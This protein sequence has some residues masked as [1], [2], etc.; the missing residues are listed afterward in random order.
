MAKTSSERSLEIIRTYVEKIGLDKKSSINLVDVNNLI[1][2]LV[3]SANYPEA[4]AVI[5]MARPEVLEDFIVNT[6]YGD[7]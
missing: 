1:L 3:E 2:S 4:E 7:E 5:I 6:L